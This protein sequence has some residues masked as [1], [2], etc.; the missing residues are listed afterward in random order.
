MG[1]V[2]RVPGTPLQRRGSL[3]CGETYPTFLKVPIAF[4]RAIRNVKGADIAHSLT[5]EMFFMK[6]Q[7]IAA[8][9]LGCSSGFAAEFTALNNATKITLADAC[10]SSLCNATIKARIKS[11]GVFSITG[12]EAAGFNADTVVKV[13]GAYTYLEF[14]I[15]DDPNYQLGDTS[16]NIAAT[17]NSSSGPIPSSLK[18]SWANN[19]VVFTSSA[20]GKSAGTAPHPDSSSVGISPEKASEQKDHY[21]EPFVPFNFF[22]ENSGTEFI[23]ASARIYGAIRIAE[24]VQTDLAGT[25]TKT[26]QINVKSQAFTNVVLP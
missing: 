1:T 21:G 16:A 19:K 6:Y 7:A 9:L 25:V 20:A 23:H 24:I 8:L 2:V 22:A 5:L 10:G 12:A 18:I 4:N 14:R 13:E 15:G 11:T 3:P 17:V 26:V